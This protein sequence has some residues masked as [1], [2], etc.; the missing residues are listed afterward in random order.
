C[1]RV[2]PQYRAAPYVGQPRPDRS[3]SRCADR[4]D[5][6]RRALQP[7]ARP[8]DNRATFAAERAMNARTDSLYEMVAG[9]LALIEGDVDPA[10]CHG[11]LCGMLCSR[12]RFEPRAWLQ[13]LC[14]YGNVESLNLGPDHA[15]SVLVRETLA[16]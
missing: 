13:H 11:M 7:T 12:R 1:N 9:A 6:G 2:T 3:A 8:W 15:L 4:P 5:R 10:E 14:G 16:A